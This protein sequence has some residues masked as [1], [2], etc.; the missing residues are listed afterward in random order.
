SFTGAEGGV[1][2]TLGQTGPQTIDARADQ[3]TLTGNIQQLFSS[4]GD[5]LTAGAGSS[6]VILFS[7]TRG[8]TLTAGGSTHLILFSGG[9]PTRRSR[10][11][12]APPTSRSSPAPRATR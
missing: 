7:L 3:L 4:G 2:L 8:D 1:T 6:D 10:P 11:R 9:A 12:T 5:S